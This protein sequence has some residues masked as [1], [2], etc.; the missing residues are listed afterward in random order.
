[1]VKYL[2][3]L[4]TK[5]LY[6]KLIIFGLLV[7]IISLFRNYP[8]NHPCGRVLDI[9]SAMSVLINCDSAVYMKDAQ[10]PIRLINGDSV[11]QDRPLPTLLVAALSKF[12]HFLNLPDYYRDV[13]GNSGQMVTYSLITYVIF[14]ALSAAI[15]SFTCYLG[16][17][18]LFQF[19]QKLNIPDE[20]FISTAFIFITSI[21]MNEITKTFF[22]T[23]GSQMF[24]LL[25]PVYAFYLISSDNKT[26]TNKF[27]LTQ[28]LIV[29]FLLFS[30]AFFVILLIPLLLIKW[31]KLRYRLLLCLIPVISYLTYPYLLNQ[32]GGVYNNYAIGYRRMY[33]WVIDAYKQNVF[34]EKLSEFLS[35]F[36]KSVPV[37]PTII[38]LIAFIA[39]SLMQKNVKLDF[40]GELVLISVHI[41]MI[42]FYGY[43]SR[44]L[45][46]PIVIF[47]LLVIL[48][49]FYALSNN[50][51][52]RILELGMPVVVLYIFISWAFTLGPLV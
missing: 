44:R 23:P 17:K 39:F 14:L 9:N 38:L 15:F 51:R 24:N 36:L 49:M 41:F 5:R 6:L 2:S 13:Q 32:F 48:K 4:F 16:I 3:K 26:I 50:T 28:I 34:Y 31:N 40:R 12:W 18:S 46:F 43:Y 25:L 27:Y 45:T 8:S 22:W 42:G 10:N 35:Y 1:M 33:V 37:L 11:Y 29:S 7:Q 52:Y 47:F 19:Q 21:S 30:Y 20:I